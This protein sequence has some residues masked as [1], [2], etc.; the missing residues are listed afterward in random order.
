MRLDEI[1][2]KGD[3]VKLKLQG[4]LDL[5]GTEEIE[6]AFTAATARHNSLIIDMTDVTFLASIGIHLLVKAQR[7][8]STRHGHLVIYNPSPDARKVLRSTGVDTIIPVTD[9]EQQAIAECSK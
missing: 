7:T 5:A 2:L 3:I 4:A 6:S 1:P 8:I 9:T